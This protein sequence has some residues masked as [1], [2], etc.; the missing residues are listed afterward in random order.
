MRG[1]RRVD[2]QGAH[3]PDVGDQGEQLQGIDEDLDIVHSPVQIEGEDAAHAIG[4]QPGDELVLVMLGKA[5]MV[6]A[7]DPGLLGESRD[8]FGAP[9]GAMMRASFDGGEESLDPEFLQIVPRPVP[10]AIT[11]EVRCEA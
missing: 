5:G 1:R 7:G 4:E 6:D 8:G 10:T 3:V 9:A 11:V 2:G